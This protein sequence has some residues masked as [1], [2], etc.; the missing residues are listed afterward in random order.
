MKE[1]KVAIIGCGS[2]GAESYGRIMA[3]QKGRFKIVSLC[4][5]DQEK[6]I[7][8]GN[9]FQVDT[10]N[11]FENEDIFFA[12]KRADVLVIATMDNDHV[13]QCEK[14]LMLGYDVLLEKPI[15][16]NKS[17]CEK[18]LATQK[19]YGGKVIVCHVL[20]YAP[21]FLKVKAILESGICGQLIM[22]DAIEQVGFWHQ[23]HS[24]VRGN[25]RNSIESSPMILQ[26]CCHDLDILQYYVGAK[27]DTISSIGDLRF[28]NRAHQP[29]G[30][31]ERCVECK[32]AETCV[33][34]ALNIYIR[35]WKEVGSPASCWPYTVL[36][37]Q[38]PLTEEALREA[39]E[40]GPYGRCVF[41]CDN[42]VV[43][44]QIV[45]MKF[46]NNVTANLRMTA[47]TP[48]GG[49]ILKLYCSEGE[50]ELNESTNK[51]EVRR[52]DKPVQTYDI[53]VLVENG[54]NHGGGDY[55][56]IEDFYK[57]LT[58]DDPSATTLEASIESHLMALAAEKSRINNGALCR[59]HEE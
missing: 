52:F 1:F 47:F 16:K 5:I 56:L 36:T 24:F 2:R 20:R 51:L 44:N 54:H 18:I 43:D 23:A 45:A 26:K 59:V 46:E 3:E 4:D 35:N 53:N 12:E 55:G 37:N 15:T 50:I 30:A 49:R 28:F 32:Y 29:K 19:K 17:E 27:C 57:V 48:G 34:S 14:A 41:C 25:W 13:R 33:Y 9:L 39:I 8:Y 31:A 10:N 42:N 11:L 6:L 38:Y 7:K 22:I 40:K 58:E 21:A